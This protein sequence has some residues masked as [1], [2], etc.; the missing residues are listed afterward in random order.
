MFVSCLDWSGWS[1]GRWWSRTALVAVRQDPSTLYQSRK[2]RS[3]SRKS[4]QAFD[5]IQEQ[6][7]GPIHCWDHRRFVPI[8]ARLLLP[9]S[10]LLHLPLQQGHRVWARGHIRVCVHPKRS[11]LLATVRFDYQFEIQKP[12]EFYDSTSNHSYFKLKAK[13]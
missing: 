6:R 3:T 13:S 10:E 9:H 7:F 5:R 8:P 11:L 12:C 4:R 2:H 1:S